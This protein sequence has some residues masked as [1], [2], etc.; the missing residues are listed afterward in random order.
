MRALML[1]LL[2]KCSKEEQ[3][4]LNR[5]VT[6]YKVQTYQS[7]QQPSII[8]LH[9][10]IWWSHCWQKTLEILGLTKTCTWFLD[11]LVIWLEQKS[12]SK[13]QNIDQPCAI[14]CV[15]K[16]F[17]T[18]T[19]RTNPNTAQ[20]FLWGFHTNILQRQ[21]EDFWLISFW[22]REGAWTDIFTPFR[23]MQH[24]L[25][26][27]YIHSQSHFRVRSSELRFQIFNPL[28]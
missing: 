3:K 6:K 2:R 9:L 13:F 20:D 12:H 19:L 15:L 17:L 8:K 14:N 22:K 27:I 28:A 23:Y 21:N 11:K 16:R 18:Q 26:S 1:G 4:S 24:R 7:L 25:S 10:G 5:L